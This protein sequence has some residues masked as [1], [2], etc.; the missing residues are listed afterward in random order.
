MVRRRSGT[1]V[2]TSS[3]GRRHGL[4]EHQM[5]LF[6]ESNQFLSFLKTRNPSTYESL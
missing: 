6:V 4:V 5:L 1:Q 3:S 2:P